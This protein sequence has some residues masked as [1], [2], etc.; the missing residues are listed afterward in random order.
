MPYPAPVQE[1]LDGE[2]FF[3]PH[4]VDTETAIVSIKSLKETSSVG[5]DGIPLNFI[6]DALYV[7]AFYL[8][9]IVNTSIAEGSV[10]TAW[11]HALV[12]PLLKV[13]M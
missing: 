5:S 13:A 4:P 8:T 2:A 7:K 3:R 10:P 1:N 12:I 11:K 6:K 9:C